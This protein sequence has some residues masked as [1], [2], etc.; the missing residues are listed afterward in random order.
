MILFRPLSHLSQ[1]FWKHCLLSTLLAVGSA[2]PAWCEEI[3]LAASPVIPAVLTADAVE[4][5]F[6][7]VAEQIKPSV[8][9]I[10]A[11]RRTAVF[12]AG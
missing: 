8:V 2:F 12:Q 6:V 7:R 5:P 4:E 11:E 1:I 3:P 9:T 10:Y